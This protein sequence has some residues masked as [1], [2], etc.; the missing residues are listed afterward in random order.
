MHGRSAF[1]HWLFGTHLGNPSHLIA[2]LG[3][4]VAIGNASGAKSRAWCPAKAR[5]WT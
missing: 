1:F 4:L 3:L 2:L 5:F